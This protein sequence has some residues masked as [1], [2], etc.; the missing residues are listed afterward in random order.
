VET[1]DRQAENGGRGARSDDNV[2]RLPR[3]WLGPLDEL[4]PVGSAARARAQG[5]AEHDSVG[6]LPPTA[7]DFWGEDSAALHDAIQAPSTDLR[8]PAPALA[9]LRS[10][11]RWSGRRFG[12]A[13]WSPSWRGPRVPGRFVLGVPAAALI[14]IAI[15]LS[16]SGAP[17]VP[18]RRA[19]A[20]AT[21]QLAPATDPGLVRRSSTAH[22]ARPATATWSVPKR[23]PSSPARPHRS[24]IPAPRPGHLAHSSAVLDTPAQPIHYAPPAYTPVSGTASVSSTTPSAVSSAARSAS[25]QASTPAGPTGRGSLIGAGTSPSG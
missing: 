22:S 20:L 21:R 1:D 7:D 16:A 17:T 6:A 8:E 4:V 11:H 12:R 19:V 10:G 5:S 15:A 3:D 18:A 23:K 2:V 13:R 25:T 14:A 24:R 9:R